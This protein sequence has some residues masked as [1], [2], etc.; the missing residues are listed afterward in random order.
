MIHA[1]FLVA[2]LLVALASSEALAA[3]QG[4]AKS[5]SSSFAKSSTS[6][7][8]GFEL[9]PLG[10]EEEQDV[11]LYNLSLLQLSLNYPSTP[12]EERKAVNSSSSPSSGAELPAAE[13]LRVARVL[14]SFHQARRTGVQVL[15]ET[16]PAVRAIIMGSMLLVILQLFIILFRSP[17][18]FLDGKAKEGS[19]KAGDLV[20]VR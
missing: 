15:V 20:E 3:Q 1:G 13:S 4:F 2:V 17:P 8:D 11:E 18:L 16:L 12:A 6:C 5:L 19:I 9:L 7:L 14:R 10:L